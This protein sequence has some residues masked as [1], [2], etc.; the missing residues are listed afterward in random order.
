MLLWV[1]L[2]AGCL[3]EPDVGYKINFLDSSK[4]LSK[5]GPL[6]GPSSKKN[7]CPYVQQHLVVSHFCISVW[8]V[9]K[10]LFPTLAEFLCPWAIEK[11]R[12][13]RSWSVYYICCKYLFPNWYIHTG[14]YYILLFTFFTGYFSKSISFWSRLNFLLFLYEFCFLYLN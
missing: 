5:A 12:I 1:R 8:S 14:T 9:G 6:H 2:T 3:Y 10:K 13:S 7:K 11:L 4:L